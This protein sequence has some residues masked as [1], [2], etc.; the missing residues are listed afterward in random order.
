MGPIFVDPPW[1]VIVML[2]VVIRLLAGRPSIAELVLPGS[3]S[4]RRGFEMNASQR[5]QLGFASITA[6][7]VA[8]W[9]VIFWPTIVSVVVSHDLG[10]LRPLALAL[11]PAVLVALA[12][13]MPEPRRAKVQDDKSQLSARP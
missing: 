9:V 1:V 13:P 8:V 7:Y 5:R 3:R 2:V 11:A 10:A 12:I 6:I 4:R